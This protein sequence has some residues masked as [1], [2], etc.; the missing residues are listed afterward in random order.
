MVIAHAFGQDHPRQ[1]GVGTDQVIGRKQR[2]PT[3]AT[4]AAVMQRVRAAVAG[5]V[6]GRIRRV[7]AAADRD[8][9]RIGTISD[10]VALVRIEGG[11]EPIG[12][13]TRE[14]GRDR[15]GKR[16]RA[17][18]VQRARHNSRR[19]HVMMS[20]ER[21]MQQSA[22]AS[23]LTHGQPC[24]VRARAPQATCQPMIRRMRRRSRHTALRQIRD[25]AARPGTPKAQAMV[26]VN[27]LGS[28]LANVGTA[29]WAR[30]WAVPGARLLEST[31][32]LRLPIVPP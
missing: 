6:F 1:R 14:R 31:L 32:C 12:G 11:E 15:Q 7:R 16:N 18:Q 28:P 10:K 30:H 20:P 21:R 19:T 4:L 17:Q 3:R 24:G 8:L 22:G 27:T 26:M 25:R 23:V 13:V 9:Q 5:V 29:R 2:P